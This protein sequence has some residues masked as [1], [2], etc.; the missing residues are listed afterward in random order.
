MEVIEQIAAVTAVLALLGG[1]LWWLRQRGYAVPAA[2]QRRNSRRMECIERLA[3]GPQQTLHL[4]RLG[5]R[6]LL[7]A[8]S[9]AGCALL[10]NLEWRDIAA[11][12]EPVR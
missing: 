11:G 12:Q 6:A 10:H 4:V 2:V 8:S 9:P 7:V 5:D 1:T 3:L